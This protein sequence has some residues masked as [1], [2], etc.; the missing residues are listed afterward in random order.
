[1]EIKTGRY[2]LLTPVQ[3][4][5]G[6]PPSIAAVQKRLETQYIQNQVDHDQ[7]IKKHKVAVDGWHNQNFSKLNDP[8]A[9]VRY[10]IRS[11]FS[12]YFLDDN[13]LPAPNKRPE[14]VFLWDMYEFLQPLRRHVDAIPGLSAKITTCVTVIA[15]AQ[16]LDRGVDTAF[17]MID[18]LDVKGDYPTLE[19]YFDLDRF[20]ARYFL[21]GLRGQP[22][23][24]KQREPL[25]LERWVGDDDIAEKL[26]QA[27]SHLPGLLVQAAVKPAKD[28]GWGHGEK[29][30]VVGWAKQVVP[31]VKSL[32]SEVAQAEM[33]TT[34]K[35]ERDKEKAILAKVKPHIDY[36]R[37]HRPPPSDPFTLNHL[38]GSYIMHCRQLQDEYGCDLGSM[39]LDIH[40]PTSSHGVVAAFDF[41]LV[42]GTMLLATS[43]EALELL[44]EE[45]PARESQ[46]E[47]EGEYVHHGNFVP[48]GKRKA[49]D[50]SRTSIRPFKRRL[51]VTEPS[52]NPGRI[53]LQWAGCQTGNSY[54][55]LDEEHK[56]TGHFDLDKSGLTAWG[57]FCY[58]E[59]FGADP[60][61][62]TLLKVASRPRKGPDQWS[63]YC[64]EERWI[65]W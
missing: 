1:M 2:W 24:E 50:S 4:V 46:S 47:S 39:T 33:R 41:G 57:Q 49:T 42:E 6:G 37:A 21:D 17:T 36:A 44:R 3:C 27:T 8:G 14:P 48:S 16:E 34:K 31:S 64:E 63:S 22:A 7:A 62:F 58:N 5:E 54:L 19:A 25:V 15:W 30:V 29:C 23:P 40:A 60:L 38:V 56:R 26:I 61:V 52:R 51:G 18:K 45:Q 55:V 35:E 28:T 13:G 43:E 9:E 32:E 20:L 12:K 59:L 11:F 65:N 10:D 53:Y